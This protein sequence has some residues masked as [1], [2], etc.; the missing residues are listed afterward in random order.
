MHEL[1]RE[2]NKFKAKYV[3][4]LSDKFKVVVPSKSVNE[5]RNCVNYRS[6]QIQQGQMRK[7]KRRMLKQCTK[8]SY[9]NSLRERVMR[10]HC[11]TTG[12]HS[13][14]NMEIGMTG[15]VILMSSIIYVDSST[16]TSLRR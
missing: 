1:D 13:K 8:R 9:Y 7:G 14:M 15:R 5:K 3:T 10:M 4:L 6:L 11:S 2:V 16:Y 12:L